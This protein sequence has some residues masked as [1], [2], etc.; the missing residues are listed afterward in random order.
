MNPILRGCENLN[1]VRAFFENHLC[2]TQSE[3]AR[4]LG[5]SPMAVNRHVRTIRNEWRQCPSAPALRLGCAEQKQEGT[6]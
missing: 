6:N 5:L 4:T 1:R 3:C 2:A